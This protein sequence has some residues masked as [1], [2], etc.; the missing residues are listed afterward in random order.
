MVNDG[1]TSVIGTLVSET[2]FSVFPCGPCRSNVDSEEFS[3]EFWTGSRNQ[4]GCYWSFLVFLLDCQ[5]STLLPSVFIEGQS[6]ASHR[7]RGGCLTPSD[8]NPQQQTAQEPRGVWM[9]GVLH[10]VGLSI[11]LSLQVSGTRRYPWIHRFSWACIR[12]IWHSRHPAPCN[13]KNSSQQIP[14]F[15]CDPAESVQVNSCHCGL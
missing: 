4:W 3:W 12:W 8:Q 9:Q 11:G 14:G 15:L 5:F 10:G 1:S 6:L 7:V 13:L 2:L